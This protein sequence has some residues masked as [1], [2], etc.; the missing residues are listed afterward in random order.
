MAE[1]NWKN[2]FALG[3]VAIHEGSFLKTAIHSIY[4]AVAPIVLTPPS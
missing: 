1:K 4:I 3:T 2:F